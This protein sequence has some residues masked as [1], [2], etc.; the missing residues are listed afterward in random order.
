[1]LIIELLECFCL[2]LIYI[3]KYKRNKYLMNIKYIINMSIDYVIINL[4]Q[5]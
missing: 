5:I 1:M 3:Y 4:I 2:F